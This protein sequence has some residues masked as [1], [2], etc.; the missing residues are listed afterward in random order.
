MMIGAGESL[1]V[2]FELP[3]S[4]L[5]FINRENKYVVESGDFRLRSERETA[6]FQINENNKPQL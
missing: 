5:G 1:D 2:T 3:V 6:S 4:E